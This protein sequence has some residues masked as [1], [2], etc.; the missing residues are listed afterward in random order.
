MIIFWSMLLVAVSAT[1]QPE[2][3]VLIG[4]HPFDG[5]LA[6]AEISSTVERGYTPVGLEVAVDEAIVVLYAQADD[7]STPDNWLLHEFE[8]INTLEDEMNALLDNGWTPMDLSFSEGRIYALLVDNG[9]E[10]SGWRVH[11]EALTRTEQ[12]EETITRFQ[13]EGLSLWGLSFDA[14]RIWYLFLRETDRESPR[15]VSIQSYRNDVGEIQTGLTE[16]LNVGWLP[17]GLFIEDDEAVTVL[18]TAEVL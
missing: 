2:S 6:A 18:Y 17:W 4:E 12:V 8:N 5:E 10:L 1:A 11:T 14:D 9:P 7:D 3:P 13:D 16:Q 15:S